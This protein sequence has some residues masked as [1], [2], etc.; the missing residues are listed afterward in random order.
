[1]HRYIT[2]PTLI[3]VSQFL[4]D[5]NLYFRICHRQLQRGKN[6]EMLQDVTR[7]VLELLDSATGDTISRHSCFINTKLGEYLV[8]LAVGR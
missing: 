3:F 1:M 4:P 5:Q 6:L 2:I 7:T 8:E